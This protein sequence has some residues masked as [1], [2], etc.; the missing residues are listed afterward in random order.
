MYVIR[1]SVRQEQGVRGFRYSIHLEQSLVVLFKLYEELGGPVPHAEAVLDE[2]IESCAADSRV[3][4]PV[5][6]DRLHALRRAK[7]LHQFVIAEP[8]LVSLKWRLMEDVLFHRTPE[9]RWAAMRAQLLEQIDLICQTPLPGLPGNGERYKLAL[10]S[11]ESRLGRLLQAGALFNFDLCEEEPPPNLSVRF[12]SR[13]FPEHRWEVRGGASA[14]G[15]E[16]L[17]AAWEPAH[18]LCRWSY[19]AADLAHGLYRGGFRLGIAPAP[20][21]HAPRAETADPEERL[22]CR[23]GWRFEPEGGTRQL[24]LLPA[25]PESVLLELQRT[26]HRRHGADGLRLFAG[27]MAVLDRSRSGKA[28]SLPLAVVAME[29]LGEV[30]PGRTRSNRVAKVQ[31]VLDRMSEVECT[32]IRESGSKATLHAGRLL[33]VLGRSEAWRGGAPALPVA[34]GQS[35]EDPVVEVL[36]DPLFY[37]ADGTT[38]GDAF[39]DLPETVNAAETRRHPY[40]VPLF[41][42]L[43]RA[44]GQSPD[45]TV[46]LTAGRIFHESGLW[47]RASSPY[48]AVEQLKHELAHL[49]DCGLLGRWRLDAGGR[50][51]PLEDQYRLEAPGPAAAPPKLPAREAWSEAFGS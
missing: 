51:E 1:G 36:L 30:R 3:P 24:E 27:L 38:L 6:Q 39:R 50:R 23:L 37:R 45:G 31:A 43:R 17:A 28:Y 40:L 4:R 46:Q 29:A 34:T 21:R 25:S 5:L 12:R 11:R 14:D 48:R 44:W 19:L 32:R 13:R 15:N 35:A 16:W 22:Y 20:E 7:D 18:P 41:V 33:T 9:S 2:R 8:D 10:S 47:V 42:W 26:V 49:K